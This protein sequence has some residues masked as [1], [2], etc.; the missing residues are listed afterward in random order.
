MKNI[1]TVT[2]SILIFVFAACN[3]EDKN[4]KKLS[5]HEGRWT[6]DYVNIIHYDS[7]GAAIVDSMITAPGELV[8][9][10]TGSLS[11]LYGY[12]QA[13]FLITDTLGTHGY[14]FDYMFDGKRIDIESCNAPFVINGTYNSVIDK[15]NEQQWEL[16][17]ANSNLTGPTTLTGK[18]ILHLIRSKN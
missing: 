16:Y 6:I 7:T 1:L 15:G 3:K 18:F 11:A 2:V 14:Y 5:R 13:V 9:F 17:G 12:R 8:L 10:R 4:T